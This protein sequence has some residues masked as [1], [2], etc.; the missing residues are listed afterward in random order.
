MAILEIQQDFRASDWES[1]G[2]DWGNRVGRSSTIRPAIQ[3][4]RRYRA[5]AIAV[6]W[7]RG[8][9]VEWG[10]GGC[11][12]MTGGGGL[13][14]VMVRLGGVELGW[15]SVGGYDDGL[16]TV[17]AR[18]WLNEG[19]GSSELVV[20]GA[21]HQIWRRW[22]DRSRVGLN[23]GVIGCGWRRSCGA[24]VEDGAVELFDLTCNFWPVEQRSAMELGLV[25]G[26][27]QWFLVLGEFR[28]SRDLV[29]V[30]KIMKA[31][32]VWT[33]HFEV[34]PFPEM[35]DLN[36]LNWRLLTWCRKCIVIGRNN[37]GN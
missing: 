16:M 15:Q 9:D 31:I 37:L 29:G 24:M 36:C 23:V 27:V 7:Q 35:V 26:C 34:L 3:G 13:W 18:S 10:A 5:W 19:L 1:S 33:L 17:W 2:S 21:K 12:I 11:G 30:A 4:L 6:D 28:W 20:R 22:C 32:L 25:C 14:G 8:R